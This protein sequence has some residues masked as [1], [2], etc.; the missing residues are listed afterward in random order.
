MNTQNGSNRRDLLKKALVAVPA[1]LALFASARLLYA[2]PAK[3]GALKLV[4]PKDPTA[5]ALKYVAKSDPKVAEKRPERSGVKGKDQ[6]C[7]N[8]SLYTKQ[9]EIDG[10]EV[11]KC[12]M[13]TSGSVTAVGWCASWAKKA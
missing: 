5:T 12:L 11:G 13:I 10:Q 3:A 2:A 1:S 9:G 8:C 7:A 6:N 4:D